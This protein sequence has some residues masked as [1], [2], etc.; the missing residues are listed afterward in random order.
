[1]GRGYY[2]VSD[3]E[4]IAVLF[5]MIWIPDGGVWIGETGI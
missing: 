1:L 4:V 2:P 5:E 3:G